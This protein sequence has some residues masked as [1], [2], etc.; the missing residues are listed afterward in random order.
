MAEGKRAVAVC[1]EHR[2][3]AAENEVVCGKCGEVLGH[4]I[5]TNNADSAGNSVTEIVDEELFTYEE[6]E[7]ASRKQVIVRKLLPANERT[8]FNAR[9]RASRDYKKE[10]D[11]YGNAWAKA[12][13]DKC[14]AATRR[15]R[16]KQKAKR[17]LAKVGS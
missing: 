3:V 5:T 15:W 6:H 17:G 12:H 16:A 1:E 11:R 8:R 10:S 7:L 2:A 13:R 4:T 9:R 14:T